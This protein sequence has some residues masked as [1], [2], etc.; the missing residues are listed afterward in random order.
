MLF[1]IRTLFQ[2]TLRENHGDTENTEAIQEQ[3]QNTGLFSCSFVC[4][5]D[6]CLFFSVSSV[7]LFQPA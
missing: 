7:V 1:H 2:H 3:N 5:V 6:R 4:F